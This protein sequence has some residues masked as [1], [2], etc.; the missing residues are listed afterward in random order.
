MHILFFSDNFPPETNAGKQNVDHCRCWAEMGHQVTV[1]TGVLFSRGKFFRLSK[2]FQKEFVCGITVIRVWTYISKNEGTIKRSLDYLS[3]MVTSFFAGLFVRDV[4]II[5][6][7]SPQF[8]TVCSAYF[9]SKMKNVPWVFELRDLWPESIKAVGA[10]TTSKL[11]RLL[12]AIELHLY[13]NS[14]LIIC[15]TKSFKEICGAGIERAKI[16]V[17]TNGA[18]TALFSPL[19]PDENLRRSLGL[20]SKFVLGYVGTHG[21]AHGLNTL[22]EAA[23]QFQNNDETGDFR[24]LFLGDGVEKDALIK[25]AHE[26]K[27]KNTIFGSRAERQSS[28]ILVYI[29]VAIHLKRE[30]LFETVIPSKLFEC[31]AMGLPVLH[32]V[33]GSQRGSLRKIAWGW[34]STRKC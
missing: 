34:C 17:I 31:M 14:D 10:I 24:I 3:Y 7:T 21:M 15:V 1:I 32:G 18:N 30:E 2:L 27:L 4:D 9:S 33:S 23:K 22:L 25:R 11:I 8:F 29:D 26:L 5:V 19:K 6:G 16:E 13:K 12:E 20:E 28:C